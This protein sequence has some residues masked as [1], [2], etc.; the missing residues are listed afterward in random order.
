M[1]QLRGWVEVLIFMILPKSEN[2]PD[3]LKLVFVISHQFVYVIKHT[4]ASCN[5]YILIA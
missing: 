2:K 5:L 4:M 3:S 1:F